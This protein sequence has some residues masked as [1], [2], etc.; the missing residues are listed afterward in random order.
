M[1]DTKIS[2][3]TADTSPTTDDL[4]VTVNDPGGTPA[5]RKVTLANLI[6]LFRKF[7]DGASINDAN[8]NELFI[9]NTIAS[10]VNEISVQNAATGNAPRLS[11]T[12]GDTNIDL[13]LRGKGTGNVTFGALGSVAAGAPQIPYFTNSS[14]YLTTPGTNSTTG[15]IGSGRLNMMPIFVPYRRA[16]TTLACVVTSGGAGGTTGRM[17]LWNA[18]QTTGKPTTLIEEGAA[19]FAVDS[20]GVKTATI[21]Q[22][23]DPGM[24]WLG[25]NSDG[26]PTMVVSTSNLSAPLGREFAVGVCN[27]VTGLYRTLSYGAFGDESASSWSISGGGITSPFLG[28]R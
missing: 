7:A 22:T 14:V 16:F 17:G 28:I 19:T 9:F 23:L 4:V 6:T 2:A 18:N 24:Y 15:A 10:A 13:N 1:A 20:T 11:A 26:T 21:S 12:G 3:L 5:N 27:V 8:A 25:L